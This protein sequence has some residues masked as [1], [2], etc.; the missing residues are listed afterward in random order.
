MVKAL[1]PVTL[2]YF[3]NYLIS[4]TMKQLKISAACMLFAAAAISFT[5]CQQA[6]EPIDQTQIGTRA[7]SWDSFRRVAYVE[8]NDVNPLNA[9]E[10][11][12]EDGKPFFTDVILFASNIRGDANGKVYN[13]NNT[14]NAA[15]FADTAK[16]IQPLRDKGIRVIMGNLGDHTGAGFSN[17]TAAQIDSYTDDLLAYEHCIDGW[18]FDD[19]WAEYGTRGYPAANTTSFSNLII[20]LNNKSDKQISVFDYAYASYINATAAA[21][22]D[23]ASYSALNGYSTTP[24]FS[25]PLSRYCPYFC[26]L[27]NMPSATLVKTR[28]TSAKNANAGGITFFNIPMSP[29]SALSRYNA[30]AQAFGHTV[31]HTGKTYSKDYG[32]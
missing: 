29:T 25:I 2:F 11:L 16:Y 15:I 6:E 14:N 21:C 12:T 5:S 3:I 7:S 26:D 1:K 19:E 27:S 22:V 10:Y 4:N 32:N 30:A 9:G 20:A 17:L 23:F 13:H 18:D 31:S 8:V 28:T 24:G